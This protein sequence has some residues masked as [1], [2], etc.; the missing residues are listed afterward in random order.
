M[1][2]LSGK[3]A[4]VTGAGAGIG[5]A[6]ALL[7]AQDGA[8]VLCADLDAGAAEATAAAVR[9]AG[10]EAAALGSDAGTED[11]QRAAVEA[12][13]AA[14]G[15]L[16]VAVNNAGVR[17]SRVFTH[18]IPRETWDHI[19]GVNLTG[20]FLG[21]QAQIPAMLKTLEAEGG[22]PARP[23][24]PDACIV[25]I[26]SILGSAGLARSAAYTA[27]KHG[28]VGLTKAAAQ[29][30]A[31]QG[32]RLNAVGPG[33]IRTEMT[34]MLDQEAVAGWHPVGRLGEAEEVA[35]MVAFLASPRARFVTGGYHAVDGGY[36]AR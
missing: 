17:G 1:G 36:L 7:L 25:N 24:G 2:E 11:G 18:E 20:V 10:G 30:Y 4:L 8:R 31:P 21:M 16:D 28:V 33:F 32:L 29:E 35:A 22:G 14:F 23:G 15:G 9:E 19:L 6:C 3:R 27:S 12:T 5:R 26:S 13:V 34:S